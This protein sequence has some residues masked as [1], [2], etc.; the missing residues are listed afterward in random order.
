MIPLRD[1]IPSRTTPFVTM[2]LIGLNAAVFAYQVSLAPGEQ[3]AFIRFFGLTP[4]S[5][6]TATLV[7]SM[8]MH[9]GW[10]HFLGNMLYLWIFGDNVEDRIGHGR[11]LVFYLM[12][13]IAASLVQAWT[14]PD[15]AIPMV[16]ASGA[17]AG[18]MGAYFVL[19]PRSRV[20][21]LIPLIIIWDVIE[22]PAIFFLG[23]WF[24][25]QLVSGLGSFAP[26]GGGI[27]FWAHVA[28]FVAGGASIF[29]FRRPERQRVEWWG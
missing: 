22:L 27:A 2:L 18:V 11:Y 9:G 1:V 23:I 12:C 21:T 25:M 7:T 29:F 3:E 8:F 5:F 15:S 17:I 28:G 14:A 16:G 20:L 26:T 10:L 19:F 6:Q 24:L 13:G 4:A